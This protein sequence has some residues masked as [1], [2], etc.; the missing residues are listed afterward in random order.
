MATKR[1]GAETKIDER[2]HYFAF[3]LRKSAI[4]FYRTLSEDTRKSYDET[5]KVFRQPYNEK[6]VVFRG[7]LAR[8]I[9]QPGEKLTEFLGD[10]QTLALKAYLQE[11]NEIREHVILRGFREGKEN[12]QVRLGL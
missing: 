3:R 11:S 5:V 7:R 4:D 10:L 1:N 8:R 9:Q 12:S 2:P 6:P